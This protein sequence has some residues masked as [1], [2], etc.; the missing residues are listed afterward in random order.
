MTDIPPP[1]PPASQPEPPP[2]PPPPPPGPPPPPPGP[3]PPPVVSAAPASSPFSDE[4]QMATIIYVLFLIAPFTLHVAGIVGLVLAYISRN[5]APEWLKSHFTF[6]IHTFWISLLYFVIAGILCVIMIGFALLPLLLIW[7]II[8][9]AL[10]L[11][12]LMRAEA[13]ANPTTWWV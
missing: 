5:S 11:A 8:R 4:R 7:Y 6:Q 10:G 13:Y 2:A 3:P 1:E 12:R 9:C